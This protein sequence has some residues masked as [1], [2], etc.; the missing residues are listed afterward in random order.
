MVN[1]KLNV[2][3]FRKYIPI[4]I[5]VFIFIGCD[6]VK[7]ND[8]DNTK[9]DLEYNSS[10]SKI[11]NDYG[12]KLGA[13]ALDTETNKEV[14][15]NA[16]DRFTYCSTFK[17]LMAGV[18][19][20]KYPLE[21]LKQVIKYTQKDILSYAPV[22]KEHVDKGM[23]IEE[24]CDAAIRYSDNT[25][26]NLLLNLIGGPSGLKSALNKLG[27]NVTE[28]A[29]IEPDLNYPIS[30]D[31]KDT[32]TPRQLA[33]DLKK[34][35]IENVLTDDKKKILINW[36]SGNSI[37]DTLIRAG[38]P[39]D[40]IVADKS[41]TGPYGIR[42]DMAVV[43]PPNRKPIFVAILTSKDSEEAKAD[44][45]AIADTSKVIFDYFTETEK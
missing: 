11:E 9:T 30:E 43:M 24:L 26:A 27:D 15:Y 13:Y 45:K 29:R 25:A 41:G 4:L 39:K 7:N 20:E 44:D 8:S 14:L 6:K 1:S 36:M 32:S 33:I 10:L 28:P 12:I 18:V 22:T 31:I 35:T 23:T 5:V 2:N 34:Y 16:D 19:L 37:G 17:A 21:Q 42:N 3:K 40:W 38:A